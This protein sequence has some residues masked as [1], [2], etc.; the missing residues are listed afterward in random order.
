MGRT[1]RDEIEAYLADGRRRQLRAA[2][3]RAYAQALADFVRSFP[4]PDPPLAALTLAAGRRWQDLRAPSVAARTLAG[5]TRSLKTFAAWV[6]AEGDL[7]AD[8]LGRLRL[9]RV[10]RHLRVV[11][12]DEELLAVIDAVAPEEQ[13]LLLVLAGTGMRVG[14]LCRLQLE[15]LVGDTLLLHDTKTREDRV[16]PLDPGLH[17]LLRFYVAELRPPAGPFERRLVLTRRRTPYQP[18]VVAALV[19]RGCARAGLGPRTFTP[20]A[21]RHWYAR[22]LIVHQTNPV[23]AAARGGWRTLAMFTYYAQVSEATMRA[24]T[25]RYAPATRIAGAMWRGASVARYAAGASSASSGRTRR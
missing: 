5:R 15:D 14:D 4:E 6:A 9:P 19:R 3:L 13:V 7:P 1:L 22:D 2:T 10:D 25:A 16:V 20:H 8:P 11:P 12:T 23:L 21:I 24:D 18:G 17:A